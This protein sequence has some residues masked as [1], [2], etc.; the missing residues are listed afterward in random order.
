M[1]IIQ[2]LII[3]L[4]CG[5][6]LPVFANEKNES[7]GYSIDTEQNKDGTITVGDLLMLTENGLPVAPQSKRHKNIL[8]VINR[9]KHEIVEL[10]DDLI[11]VQV[12][13]VDKNTN[14]TVKIMLVEYH[15][16][17]KKLIKGP[18]VIKQFTG[19]YEY[20]TKFN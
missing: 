20:K 9:N 7:P 4:S 19:K 18:I 10:S 16:E 15:F 14:E 1:K 6:A 2:S 8:K 3:I 17:N 5:F 13:G 12:N 11:L